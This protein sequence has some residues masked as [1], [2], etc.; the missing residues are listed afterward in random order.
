MKLAMLGLALAITAAG[1]A[2]DGGSSGD[3]TKAD[4]KDIQGDAA[5]QKEI[6]AAIRAGYLDELVDG[7]VPAIDM[8]SLRI[9]EDKAFLIGTVRAESGGEIDWEKS[10][11]AMD[12]AEGLFD[13]PHL[14]ALLKREDGMWRLITASVGSTDVWWDGLW[15]SYPVSCDLFPG[16]SCISV[17]EPAP[18]SP[19]REALTDAIH[20]GGL[21]ASLRGQANELRVSW[22]RAGGDYA[23]A[24]AEVTGPGGAPI[25]WTRTD[26]AD[27]VEAG[28]FDGPH[29]TATLHKD[30]GSYKVLQLSVGATDV[31]WHGA[32]SEYQDFACALVPVDTC[33]LED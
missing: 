23:F 7:Q 32:W 15:L 12:V 8:T 30:G 4:T 20:A 16:M 3:D 18:G 10:D 5:T 9:A 17:V 13:G 22:L 14:E 1:C 24:M 27:D 29:L 11:A 28:L 33:V 6:V 26:Y 25:D 21:D 31:P 19:E 2:A